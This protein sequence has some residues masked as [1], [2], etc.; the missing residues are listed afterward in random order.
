MQ[1]GKYTQ[2]E[3]TIQLYELDSDMAHML[4]LSERKYKVIMINI[5]RACDR[6]PMTTLRLT[7]LLERHPR[8]GKSCYTRD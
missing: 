8:C 7:D 3:K 5:L 2:W 6:V 4:K 1:K